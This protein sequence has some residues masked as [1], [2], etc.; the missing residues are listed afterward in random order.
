M[1]EFKDKV[2]GLVYIAD[3]GA[4]ITV[5]TRLCSLRLFKI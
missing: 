5:V 2:F 3:I 1:L 4:V